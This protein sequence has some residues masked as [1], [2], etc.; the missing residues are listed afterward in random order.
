[1]TLAW[2]PLVYFQ[3]VHQPNVRNGNIA[4]AVVTG[5]TVIVFVLITVL[6]HREER[7]KKLAGLLKAPA[8]AAGSLDD[9]ANNEK[10]SL[11]D[12]EDVVPVLASNR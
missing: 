3:Q 2:V 4:A 6:A 1:M 9:G 8:S 5:F 7:Q 11:S 12:E 10:V